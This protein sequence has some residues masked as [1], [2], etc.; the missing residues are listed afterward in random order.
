M[1]IKNHWQQKT[2]SNGARTFLKILAPLEKKLAKNKP[3]KRKLVIT[4][5]GEASVGKTVVGKI[6]STYF[7]LK[8]HNVGDKERHFAKKKKISLETASQLLPKKIDLSV[9]KEALKLAIEGGCV[10]VGRLAAFT[11]GDWA[12]CRILVTCEGKVRAERLARKFP[13]TADPPKA[14]KIFQKEALKKLKARDKADRKRYKK[15]YGLDLLNKNPYN[16]IIDNT[17]P[18]LKEIKNIVI[19]KV[20]DF[21]S[22]FAKGY[23]GSPEAL[24]EG[25]KNKNY[26]WPR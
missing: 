16:L 15:L 23:G 9:D 25:G 22:T 2:A 5:S 6:L 3:R 11:V 12:D 19:K 21:L 13:P 7:N 1:F 8:L 4:I 24:C 18:S 17:K 26:G 14:E 20:E 10:I